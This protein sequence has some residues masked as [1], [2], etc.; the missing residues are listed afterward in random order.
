MSFR[1]P[2]S[3]RQVLEHRRKI[4]SVIVTGRITFRR[5][6]K[7]RAPINRENQELHSLGNKLDISPDY[8][9]LS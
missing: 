2:A 7:L 3:S 9:T 5:F 8:E 6:D 4:D 1:A